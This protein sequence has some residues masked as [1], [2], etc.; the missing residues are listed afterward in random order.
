[1]GYVRLTIIALDAFFS[2]LVIVKQV[3]EED[4]LYAKKCFHRK[5]T[6][7]SLAKFCYKHK[8]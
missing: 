6:F 1:M 3:R 7:V 2:P 5:N 8:Q 4:F